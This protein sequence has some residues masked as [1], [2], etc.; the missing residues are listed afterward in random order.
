MNAYDAERDSDGVL[1]GVAEIHGDRLHL[2]STAPSAALISDFDADR[3]H[4]DSLSRLGPP[5]LGGAAIF[6]EG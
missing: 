1:L 4:L 6:A 3:S 5:V 2:L